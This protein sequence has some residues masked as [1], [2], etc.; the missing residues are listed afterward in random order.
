MVKP[1]D[2]Q[3]TGPATGIARPDGAA[4]P[5][6]FSGARVVPARRSRA[7]QP[8]TPAEPAAASLLE[9]AVVIEAVPHLTKA[10]RLS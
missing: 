1:A 4:V 3:R 9:D 10:A 6:P 7:R 5:S 8:G 2:N